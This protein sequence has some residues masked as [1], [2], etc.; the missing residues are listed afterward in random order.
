MGGTTAEAVKIVCQDDLDKAKQHQGRI[1]VVCVEDME[2]SSCRSRAAVE[3]A[4]QQ[5]PVAQ[6][7]GARGV[8]H[9][10][11]IR[12]DCLEDIDDHQWRKMWIAAVERA[13][14]RASQAPAAYDVKR[15]RQHPY[16]AQDG[17]FR[18]KVLPVDKARVVTIN[19]LLLT[20]SNGME[21]QRASVAPLPKQLPMPVRWRPINVS[22]PQLRAQRKQ[23]HLTTP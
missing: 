3:Q 16:V 14:E 23:L 20:T 1:Q 15:P 5:L 13:L 8:Q 17:G 2:A 10:R 18:Y 7:G 11:R 12:N 6:D 4:A 22:Q 9:G 19:D 21:Q